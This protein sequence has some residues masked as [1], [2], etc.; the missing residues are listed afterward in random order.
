MIEIQFIEKLSFLLDTPSRYKVLYG[1][2]G[3]GK[4]EGVA[5]ALIIL[6]L[7]K[8]LRIACFREFQKSIKESVHSLIKQKIYDI[9]M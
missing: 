9:K 7:Q 2:R 4:S 1:G 5:T 6:S 8:S 3:G